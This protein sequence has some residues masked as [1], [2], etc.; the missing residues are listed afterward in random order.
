MVKNKQVFLVEEKP[1][2]HVRHLFVW[3]RRCIVT[4]DDLG[5]VKQTNLEKGY[6]MG[7]YVRL[8]EK[9]ESHIKQH[10]S[11]D[12]F[13]YP[14]WIRI[15]EIRR[16]CFISGFMMLGLLIITLLFASSFNDM[17]KPVGSLYALSIL[18]C[19]NLVFFGCEVVKHISKKKLS[20]IHCS[21]ESFKVTFTDGTM[22]DFS[23]DQ[24]KH[25]N[26]DVA[27]K[28]TFIHFT[29]GTHIHHL[30]R[31]SYWPILREYL[32][33]KLEQSKVT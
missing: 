13:E 33:S 24:I 32:L 4:I 31:V 22:N 23:F 28:Y 3:E 11:R 25:F 17:H 29:D 19:A 20:E 7:D 27:T 30:E 12:S 5:R 14:N 2:E 18:I 21:F 26:F 8:W 6:K 1:L 16:G 15:K 10:V 9:W